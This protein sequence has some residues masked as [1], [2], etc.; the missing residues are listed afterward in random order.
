VPSSTRVCLKRTSH[1]YSPSSDATEGIRGTVL[2]DIFA[3]ARNPATGNFRPQAL[4]EQLKLWGDRL[5]DILTPQQYE[6]VQDLAKMTASLAKGQRVAEGSQTAYLLRHG[7]QAATAVTSPVLALKL[8]AGDI[9]LS[10]LIG[11]KAG[12]Q[13]LTR[14]FGPVA[15][16]WLA[17]SVI[18][19]GTA[20]GLSPAPG[21]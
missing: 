21:R 14:G 3:K 18:E 4:S 17:R 8:V 20:L 13:W 16:P 7:S 1:G 5:Q 11:S 6:T 19:G 10:K 2:A 12:Q 9:A 15:V